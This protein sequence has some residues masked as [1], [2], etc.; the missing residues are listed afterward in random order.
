MQADKR[1]VIPGG[2]GFLGRLLAES[3]TAR[4]YEI[5]VL[6]RTPQPS[7]F[8]AQQVVWD[9]TTLGAWA[10]ELE[11][12]AAVI[13]LAGRSVNCRYNATNRRAIY[14]SR[15]RSTAAI[16]TAIAQCAQPPR[17]WLNAS[18]ATIYRDARDRAM[19][20]STGDIGT[21]FSVDVCQQWERAF[22]EAQT[23]HTRKVA[24]RTA[25]VF[26]DGQGGPFE[27]FQRL[28]RFGL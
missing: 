18:S 8:P 17:V 15:L 11:G 3:L 20:E 16:D 21:G 13:N 12:A 4:G 6:T 19:D 10:K 28:V 9:G 25:I 23:P 1:I 26:G 24:L 14:A 22:A 27:A 5:V 7:P 2:T